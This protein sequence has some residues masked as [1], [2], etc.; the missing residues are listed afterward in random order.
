M[1]FIFG[2]APDSKDR[3]GILVF[4]DHFSKMTH[5]VPVHATIATIDTVAHFVDAV[6]RH[7]GLPEN[8]VSDRDPRFTSAFWTSSLELLSTKLQ[9][10]TAAHPETDGQ[11]ER[12]NRVLEDVLRS[13][14]TSFSSWSAFLN[15]LLSLHSKMLCTR[16]Q[17]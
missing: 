16:Q 5:L 17:G 1:D 9:M 14:E 6:F 4:G 3:T 15:H 2:L 7:H 10:S 12:V 11:T 13:N 8:F